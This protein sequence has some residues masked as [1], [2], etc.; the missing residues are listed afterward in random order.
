[1][2]TAS[3]PAGRP[4]AQGLAP[5]VRKAGRVDLVL[6]VGAFALFVLLWVGFA[7]ALA[8]NRGLLDAAWDWL[9][10]LPTPAQV[11]VWVAI[12]PIAVGLWIWE[13]TWPSI[14]GFSLAAGMVAWTLV[15]VAGLARAVR[16]A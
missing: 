6:A 14:V 5:S 2:A 9:R 12:L 7:V 11:V 4:S 16:A 15:A 3:H 10:G 1:M 8:G 13:S